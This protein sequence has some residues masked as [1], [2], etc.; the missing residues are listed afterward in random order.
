MFYPFYNTVQP[1]V[2]VTDVPSN[3]TLERV[4]QSVHSVSFMFS[5]V[6]G[7]CKGACSCLLFTVT[8]KLVNRL[9]ASLSF[10]SPL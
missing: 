8:S 1:L 9:I 5:F 10:P 4:P 7:K 2:D 3:E 6:A